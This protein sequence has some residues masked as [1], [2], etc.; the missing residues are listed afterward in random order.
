MTLE[1]AAYVKALGQI[2]FVFAL[3]VSTFFFRERTNPR[4]L[5]GMALIAAGVLVLV[6]AG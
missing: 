1:R 6:L 5:S 2:E 4:E 3:G